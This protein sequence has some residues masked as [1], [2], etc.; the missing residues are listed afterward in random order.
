MANKFNSI[1]VKKNNDFIKEQRMKLLKDQIKKV[2]DI[3]N[4]NKKREINSFTGFKIFFK[5]ISKLILFI[6]RIFLI[7]ILFGTIILVLISLFYPES[8]QQ[9]RDISQLIWEKF[10]KSIT[11]LLN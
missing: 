2:T 4:H 11:N 5:Y 1:L 8:H 3:D 9:F 6:I 7:L 10:I